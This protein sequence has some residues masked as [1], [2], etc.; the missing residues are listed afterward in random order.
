[1]SQ[2][3][4]PFF[5]YDGACGF[6]QRWVRWLQ[7]RVPSEVAFVRF[8]DIDDLTPYGIALADVQTASYWID[9]GDRTFRGNRSIARVLQQGRGVW[10]I[11]GTAL[12]LPVAR[13]LAGAAY[14]VISRNRHRLPAPN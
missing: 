3:D 7:R 9:D 14:A 8:Q 11:V 5:V 10:R 6:C 12:D 4:L 2:P 13:T 1:V